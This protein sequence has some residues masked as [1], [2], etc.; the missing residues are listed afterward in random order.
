MNSP[1]IVVA[2]PLKLGT[3]EIL[4]LNILKENGITFT[5]Q[6]KTI[7]SK[8]SREQLSGTNQQDR[9]ATIF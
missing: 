9:N 8:R 2:S 3:M 1:V 4:T 5:I 7:R 6:G